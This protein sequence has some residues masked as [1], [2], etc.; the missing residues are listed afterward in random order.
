LQQGEERSNDASLKLSAQCQVLRIRPEPENDLMIEQG[1][2]DAI[3]GALETIVSDADLG[4]EEGYEAVFL[5]YD[6]YG[7]FVTWARSGWKETPQEM[8]ALVPGRLRGRPI[9]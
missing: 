6:L 9:G 5:A 7:L 8:A 4:R 1:R 3:L 2:T